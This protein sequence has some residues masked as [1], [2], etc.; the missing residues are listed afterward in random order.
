L[1]GIM[2]HHFYT[3]VP[4]LAD[5]R[6]DVPA[7]LRE[8]IDRALAKKPE[9]RFAT[10]EAMVAALETVSFAE[11]DRRQGLAHL[12][13][14]AHGAPIPVVGISALPAL[15]SSI[16]FTPQSAPIVPPPRAWWRSRWMIAGMV[17][18]LIGVGG[19]ASLVRQ[20]RAPTPRV[21]P[22]IV[23]TLPP[24]SA[25]PVVAARVDSAPSATEPKAVGRLRVRAFPADAEIRVDGRVLGLGV[26][27]DSVV[28]A[29]ARRL[30]VTA[31]G[32][33][34]FDTTITVVADEITAL[35]RI[36]LPLQE[37]RQ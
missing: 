13:D 30:R 17:T 20:Q 2:H 31:P 27:L 28:R 19:A 16:R 1:P 5:A 34:P 14:L 33:E 8:V 11:T 23:P 4:D 25:P 3:R 37:P 15:A 24:P 21:A 6:L 18:A 26:V 9:S 10:T 29:G 36:T 32:H 22:I 7:S 12:R 35:S